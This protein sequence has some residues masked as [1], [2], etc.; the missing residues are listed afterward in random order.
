[1]FRLI[2]HLALVPVALPFAIGAE[3]L[4]ALTG[5]DIHDDMESGIQH[6][7]PGKPRFEN[8]CANCRGT[9]NE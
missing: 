5:K 4:E 3:V 2:M 6:E 8:R 9:D 1:M 7:P